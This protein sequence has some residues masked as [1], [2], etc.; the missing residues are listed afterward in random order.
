[1]DELKR[2]LE[3]SESQNQQMKEWQNKYEEIK[4]CLLESELEQ[5]RLF[6][7]KVEVE[8]KVIDLTN[9]SSKN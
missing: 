5:Q 4:N 7:A 9:V 2:Q 6:E 3:K 8:T 1:M